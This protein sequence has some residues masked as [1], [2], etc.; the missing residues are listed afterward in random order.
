MIALWVAA[1]LAGEP[2]AAVGVGAIGGLEFQTAQPF[3]GVDLV[4]WPTQTLGPAPVGRLVLG[5]GIDERLP[6]GFAEVGFT[7][8]IANPE[9]TLRIGAVARPMIAGTHGRMPL[10]F[11]NTGEAEYGLLVGGAGLAELEWNPRAPLTLGARAGIGPVGA[12]YG[13]DVEPVGFD[14][15]RVWVPGFVGGFVLRKRFP[16][17]LALEAQLGTTSFLAVEARLGRLAP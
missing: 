15:C 9:A 7:W 13:C 12:G 11:A 14:D 2:R 4:V 5:V 17:R 3:A 16:G 6:L 8:G 1:A 10:P